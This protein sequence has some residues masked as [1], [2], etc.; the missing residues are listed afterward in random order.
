MNAKEKVKQSK[1]FHTCVL[2]SKKQ[3]EHA[4]VN[5]VLKTFESVPS[6]K[7]L[8]LNLSSAISNGGE[9]EDS[10]M[11]AEELKTQ[12]ERRRRDGL[13]CYRNG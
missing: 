7:T 9:E 1:Y 11:I 5:N 12:R 4:K 13:S 10:K 3:K 8:E 6:Q 2:A